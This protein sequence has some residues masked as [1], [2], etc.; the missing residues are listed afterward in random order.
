[1]STMT[2]SPT[3]ATG[4][5]A[6]LRLVSARP[7]RTVRPAAAPRGVRLTRRGRA[8]LLGLCLLLVLGAALA[9]ATA[10]AATDRPGAEVP[11]EVIT[12]ATG[13]TLWAIASER[14]ATG[15]EI[16]EVMREIERLNALETAALDAG[17]RLRVP[18]AG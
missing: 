10:S 13:D 5:A 4:A 12:V 6:T 9:L 14:A 11:T 1:M 7:V 2:L 16:R 18:V 15:S 8:V 17:Q 3:A